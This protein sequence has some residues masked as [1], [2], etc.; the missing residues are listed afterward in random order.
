MSSAEAL[1][2]LKAPTFLQ[3]R[4]LLGAIFP[5]FTT[6]VTALLVINL[7][8]TELWILAVGWDAQS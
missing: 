1:N 4:S 2:N 8:L 5:L 7:L 6:K 3:R